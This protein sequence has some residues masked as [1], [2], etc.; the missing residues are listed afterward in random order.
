MVHL[1]IFRYETVKEI[2][3]ETAKE[4]SNGDKISDNLSFS[5]QDQNSNEVIELAD[6]MLSVNSSSTSLQSN[7]NTEITTTAD[8]CSLK[9]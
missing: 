3:K 4:E 1:F 6:S 2:K 8:N 9:R 5:V 7:S